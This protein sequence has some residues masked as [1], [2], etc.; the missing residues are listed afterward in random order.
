M[1]GLFKPEVCT[2][3]CVLYTAMKKHWGLITPCFSPAQLWLR[4]DTCF[5]TVYLRDVVF[6][7]AV[8]A[9]HIGG[10]LELGLHKAMLRIRGTEAVGVVVRGSTWW[11][12]SATATSCI[13]AYIYFQTMLFG[14]HINLL[15]VEAFFIY[16]FIYIF[17]F[18][19]LVIL[20]SPRHRPVVI[21]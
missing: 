7:S 9:T 1:E 19:T 16:L 6:V 4:N 8:V 17:Y 13:S 15:N 12:E 11:T 14:G 18:K 20:G 5:K 2:N 10:H 3:K 21:L